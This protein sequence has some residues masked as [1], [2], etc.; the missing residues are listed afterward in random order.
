[1]TALLIV[2]VWVG[3]AAVL[4]T[5]IGKAVRLADRKERGTRD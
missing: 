4:G 5:L 3:A 2:V 1:M